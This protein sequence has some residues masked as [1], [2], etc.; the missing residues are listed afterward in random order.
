MIKE[1]IVVLYDGADCSDGFGG[2]WVAWKKFKNKAKYIGVFHQAPVPEGIKDKI[3]YTIDFAYPESV[4]RQLMKDNISV[5]SI[6]HHISAKKAIELTKN[7]SY[8]EN[9]SGSVLAWKY[10]FPDKPIPKLLKY[11]EDNDLWKHKLPRTEEI[12]LYQDLSGFNF[13]EWDKLAKRLEDPQKFKEAVSIGNALIKFR[14]NLIKPILEKKSEKILF[15]GH[16]A[17]AVNSPFFASE[18]GNILTKKDVDVGVVWKKGDNKIF[19]SLRGN[20]KV[21]VSKLAQKY[22]GGGHKNAA[23][24]TLPDFPLPWKAIKE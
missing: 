5:T 3:V 24:F 17:L 12:F 23:G 18:I 21:D 13:K 11:V 20:G 15:E 4:T 1:K 7:Y 10:F 22:G 2:A 9:N 14:D 16:R 6:D 8:S 19:V